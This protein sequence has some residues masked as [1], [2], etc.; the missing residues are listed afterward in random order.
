MDIVPPVSEALA[1]SVILEPDVKAVRETTG[2]TAVTVAVIEVETV[3]EPL[4]SVAFAVK[5]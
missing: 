3:A 5:L 1:L 4:E 2:G